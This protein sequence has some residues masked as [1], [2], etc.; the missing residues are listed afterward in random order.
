MDA[1]GLHVWNAGMDAELQDLGV[2]CVVGEDGEERF[3]RGG[4]FDWA[5][6]SAVVD[7]ES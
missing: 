7:G 4:F 5:T 1:L 2:R 6:R 3:H